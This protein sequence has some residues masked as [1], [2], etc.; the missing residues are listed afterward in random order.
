MYGDGC[1]G[2]GWHYDST[3]KGLADDVQELVLRIGWAASVS[4]QTKFPKGSY[5]KRPMYRVNVNRTRLVPETNKRKP[6]HTLESY[7]GL[8]Y[9]C[10]VPSGLVFVR[11]NGKCVWSSNSDDYWAFSLAVEAGSQPG[12]GLIESWKKQAEAVKTKESEQRRKPETAEEWAEQSGAAQTREAVA[13]GVFGAERF[14]PNKSMKA[15]MDKITTSRMI[16]PDT[17]PQTQ[18]CPKCGSKA[19]AVYAEFMRCNQCRH[20]WPKK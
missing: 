9:C 14:D 12:H 6:E 19:L 20:T 16:K 8:V 10:T 5:N 1:E 13:Q 3:S 4:K 11:R 15:Q 2:P 18:A 17:A 7:D